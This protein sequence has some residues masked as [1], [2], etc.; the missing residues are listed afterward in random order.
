[1]L[2]REI[3]T[4]EKGVSLHVYCTQGS[5]I[6]LTA[7]AIGIANENGWA[8]TRVEQR[9]DQQISLGHAC[10]E[11]LWLNNIPGGTSIIV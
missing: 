7:F 8:M 6:A 2:T 1:M 10:K 9:I 5:H 11:Q 4:I 3:K